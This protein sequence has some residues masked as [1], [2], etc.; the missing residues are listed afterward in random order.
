ME[1]TK[2]TKF[3]NEDYPLTQEDKEFLSAKTGYS[4][5]SID[6]ILRG[7][8]PHIE[9]HNTLISLYQKM[10]QLKKLHRENYL[11]DLNNI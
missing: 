11:K 7:N 5:F 2:T 6:Q 1:Q 3:I 8:V 4:S 9:R 10:V